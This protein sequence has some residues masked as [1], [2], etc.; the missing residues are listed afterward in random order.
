M[1]LMVHLRIIAS[2]RRI[3]S[4]SCEWL[5]TN[6]LSH[7]NCSVW[8]RRAHV[9]T[10]VHANVEMVGACRC[11]SSWRWTRLLHRCPSQK[12]PDQTTDHR[13]IC[14]WSGFAAYGRIVD[15][16]SASALYTAAIALPQYRGPR[17]RRSVIR[18]HCQCALP[19][20]M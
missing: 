17:P 19:W 20:L 11:L 12:P 18:N 16:V 13:A 4:C 6:A 10:R 9:C 7:C 3:S 5:E 15:I 1:V 14:I 8:R 2:T